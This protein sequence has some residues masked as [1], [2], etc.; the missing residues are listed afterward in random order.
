MMKNGG[1][2]VIIGGGGTGGHVFLPFSIANAIKNVGMMQK[3]YLLEQKI[4]WRCSVYRRRV[5][6][7]WDFP[8]QASIASIC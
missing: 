1:P 5:I 3:F 6:K 4:V 7:L 8:F 2:R